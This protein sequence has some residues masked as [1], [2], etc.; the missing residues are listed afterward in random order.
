MLFKIGNL[1]LYN[2]HE[3]TEDIDGKMLL[4]VHGLWSV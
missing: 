1:W 2:F 3:L 4:T